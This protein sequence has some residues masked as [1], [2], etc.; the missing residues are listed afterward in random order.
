M[1]KPEALKIGRRYQVTQSSLFDEEAT[2]QDNV[3]F[4]REFLYAMHDL[5]LDDEPPHEVKDEWRQQSALIIGKSPNVQ[6][7]NSKV[8]SKVYRHFHSFVFIFVCCYLFV[9]LFN[10]GSIFWLKST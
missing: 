3:I 6:S 1:P 8:P 9:Y 4:L 10:L 2:L 5:E 7:E